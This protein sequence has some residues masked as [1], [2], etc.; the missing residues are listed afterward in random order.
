MTPHSHD[1]Q[2]Q[3]VAVAK[4]GASL[5][6][7]AAGSRGTL[8]QLMPDHTT[9]VP[10]DV[11]AALGN[12]DTVKRS[13]RRERAKHMP[14]NP[15][16]LS[17]LMLDGEWTT[18][19][20]GDPFVIYDNGVDSSARMLVFGT[21]LGLR[22]LASS[23]SWF[24][25][26]TFDVAP[27]LFTQLYVIRVPLG[28]SAVTCVYAFLPN[29]HQETYEELFS[30]I[31]DRCTELGFNV[32]PTTVTMDFEQAVIN[33][34]QSSFG[35][36]VNIHGCFYHLAQSTWRKIQSLGLVQHYR[37]E[38]DVKLFCGMMDGLAFLP[39]DDVPDGMAY[40]RDNIPEGLEPLLQYFDQIYVSGTYHQ[41]QLLQRPDGTMPPLRMRRKPPMYPPSIWNVHNITLHGSSRTNNICEGWNNAFSNLVGHAHP[42]IWR[43]ID[44]IRKDQAQVATAL[45]RDQHGEPPVKQT[46]RHTV[47]LQTKLHNLCTARRDGTKS[48]PDTL[49]G[50]GHCVRWK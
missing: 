45:L 17:E 24:M 37:E 5:K 43:A 34:M 25:D 32:D 2:E 48:I 46:R 13:L 38:D 1:P 23:D 20:D 39:E 44:S 12:P 18:T 41:I 31:Q 7:R 40:L 50:I 11:H 21:D 30:A 49:R 8:T 36:H 35:P 6:E 10:V 22:H 28:E 26:G 29:K 47:Q 16:S 3:S 42:T 9:D 15:A 19:V 33:A 27:L 14:K 4:L